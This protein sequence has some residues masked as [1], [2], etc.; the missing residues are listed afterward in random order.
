MTGFLEIT[1]GPMFS[2]KTI[3]LLEKIDNY[4]TYSR[5]TGQDNNVL[6]INSFTDQ[7]NN[8]VIDNLSTHESP[9]KRNINSTKV[10]TLKVK[11]LANIDKKL[12]SS[13]NYIAIDEC[14][15]FTDLEIFVKLWLKEGKHIHCSG[16]VADSEKR[17]FGQLHT[18]FCLADKIDQLKAYC[19][20]C[21]S[22]EKNAVFTKWISKNN[23]S[24]KVEIGDSER[25]A[26]V[27]G[28][29]YDD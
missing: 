20:K 17:N 5:I 27:C 1:F 8:N 16:L 18:I 7:R 3:A 29:H 21:N 6:I 25:Y 19:I 12:L 24:G 15:F 23:K 26:P 4:L 28:N 14:Q 10:K 22:K 11:N 9:I 2:G 13:F